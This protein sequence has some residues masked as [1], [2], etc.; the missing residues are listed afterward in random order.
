M[1]DDPDRL[2]RRAIRRYALDAVRR[3][4]PPRGG[5]GRIQRAIVRAFDYPYSSNVDV[6]DIAGPWLAIDDLRRAVGYHDSWKRRRHFFRALEGLLMRGIVRLHAG[7]VGASW[8]HKLDGRW[9]TIVELL[10]H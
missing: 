3:R 10:S 6:P 4:C 1:T 5:L 8:V 7:R 9:T 2:M